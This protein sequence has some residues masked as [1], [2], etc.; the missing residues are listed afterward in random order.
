MEEAQAP[1]CTHAA[2]HLLPFLKP[3]H[4]PTPHSAD[5]PYPSPPAEEPPAEEPPSP[6][7]I[8]TALYNVEVTTEE[9]PVEEGGVLSP[10]P[11]AKG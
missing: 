2:Q 3:T 5:S 6:D 1:R 11:P 9:T 7:I 10:P 4:A 8:Y